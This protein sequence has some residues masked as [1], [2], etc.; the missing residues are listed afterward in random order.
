MKKY[1]ILILFGILSIA[2]VKAQCFTYSYH[3]FDLEDFIDDADTVSCDT[4][5]LAYYA[6]GDT[7][8][9]MRINYVSRGGKQHH[10]TQ[11][12]VMK[13]QESMREIQSQ[14][15]AFFTDAMKLTP[16]EAQVFWPLYNQYSEKKNKLAE[17][18]KKMMKSFS[19]EG[20]AAMT[21]SE[22]TAA[23]NTYVKLQQQENDLLQEYHQKFTKQLPTKKVLQ[24]YKAEK[25]FMQNLLWH[26]KGQR[27]GGKE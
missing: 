10:Q 19:P 8:S 15:V 3:D 23:A 22:A 2:T 24:M 4:Y 12:F 18:Q 20:I 17:E 7:T 6:E 25:D 21:N 13:R 11:V 5:M 27:K 16:E 9:S 1:S 26:L 14:R